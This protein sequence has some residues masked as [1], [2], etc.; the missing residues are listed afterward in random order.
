V[1]RQHLGQHRNPNIKSVK[2]FTD[3]DRIAIPR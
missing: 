1:R 2:D 3:K